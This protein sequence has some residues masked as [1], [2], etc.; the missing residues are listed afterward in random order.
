MEG[1]L[2][3]GVKDKIMNERCMETFKEEKKRVKRIIYI[4]IKRMVRE[5]SEER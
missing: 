1:C 4:K 5:I 3:L 2:S